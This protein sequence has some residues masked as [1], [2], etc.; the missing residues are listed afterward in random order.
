ML[1][2]PIVPCSTF[3]ETDNKIW[4]WHDEF[5]VSLWWCCVPVILFV[6]GQHNLI[7]NFLA[8]QLQSCLSFSINN[9]MEEEIF[10]Q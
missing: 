4:K 5:N 8:R 10:S 7:A 1:P 6:D 2:T 3:V 9:K